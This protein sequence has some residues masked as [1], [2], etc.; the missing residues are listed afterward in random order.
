MLIISFQIILLNA[1]SNEQADLQTT[2]SQE[3]ESTA[4][5]TKPKLESK[6]KSIKE[7]KETKEIKAVSKNLPFKTTLFVNGRV[8]DILLVITDQKNK[9]HSISIKAGSHYSCGHPAQYL[10]KVM[11][12]EISAP[13]TTLNQAD[14]NTYS[15]F[16]FN[17]DQKL[18]KYHFI[19]IQ[20]KNN[21]LKQ[22]RESRNE[23][24]FLEVCE[25]NIYNP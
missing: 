16:V 14:L 5:K 22:A 17:T 6:S 15:V 13:N 18:E 20:Q 19:N 12:Y 24:L 23:A 2:E 25:H 21:S 4:Q 11:C 3:S 9:S 10:K 1:E 7:K 8:N